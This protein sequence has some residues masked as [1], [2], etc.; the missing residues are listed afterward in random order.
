MELDVVRLVGEGPEQPGDRRE[1]VH[2]AW[3]GEGPPL[4]RLLEARRVV[5]LGAGGRGGASFACF[6]ALVFYQYRQDDH[7]T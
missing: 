4:A 3:D 6:D 7:P 5:A 1:A 2:H